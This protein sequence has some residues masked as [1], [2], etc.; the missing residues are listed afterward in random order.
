MYVHLG[1]DVVVPVNEVVAIVDA[2]L[3]EGSEINRELVDRAARAGRLRGAGPSPGWKAL[4]VTIH[5]V[6]TSGV[7]ASTLGRRMTHLRQAAIS[8]EAETQV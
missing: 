6:Y 1:G 3:F 4:V 2:R 8:W 7:S 5:A